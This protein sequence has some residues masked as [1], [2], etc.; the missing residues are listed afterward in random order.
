MSVNQYLTHNR[1]GFDY[2]LSACQHFCKIVCYGTIIWVK[3][4]VRVPKVY[5]EDALTN[6]K[7]RRIFFGV[8]Q[9]W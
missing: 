8:S 1:F 7:A 5:S 2:L 6:G 3:S 9:E 4:S